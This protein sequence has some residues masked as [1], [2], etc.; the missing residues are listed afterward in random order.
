M[1]VACRPHQ[2]AATY[3]VSK[4]DKEYSKVGIGRNLTIKQRELNPELSKEV[5]NRRKDNPSENWGIWREKTEAA[6]DGY[7]H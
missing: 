1:G 4:F 5:M 6:E 7:T 3:E 2:G